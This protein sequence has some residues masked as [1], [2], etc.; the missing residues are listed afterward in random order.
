MYWPMVPM[1]RYVTINHA[2]MGI[3]TI[4]LYFVFLYIKNIDIVVISATI[5]MNITKS[6][7]VKRPSGKTSRKLSA[8]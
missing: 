5:A 4:L 1:N 7:K 8:G 6:C 3:R 2:A